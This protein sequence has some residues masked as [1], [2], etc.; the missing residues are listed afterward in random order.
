MFDEVFWM[1]F[2][3]FIGAFLLRVLQVLEFFLR[4][5]FSHYWRVSSETLL[6]LYQS[7]PFLRGFLFRNHWSVSFERSFV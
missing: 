1:I 3:T 5:L 2:Y 4:D 7:V 6:L